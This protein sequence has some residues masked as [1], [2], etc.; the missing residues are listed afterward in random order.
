MVVLFLKDSQLLVTLKLHVL[1]HMTGTQRT[2]KKSVE[3]TH[4]FADRKESG[5]SD[6]SK[7]ALTPTS[8]TTILIKA[9]IFI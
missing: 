2:Q 9:V 6:A 3:D 8:F 4:W 1:G 5:E 7:A